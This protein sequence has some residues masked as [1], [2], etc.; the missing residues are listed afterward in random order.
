PGSSRRR[1]RRGEQRWDEQAG[2]ATNVLLVGGR[3]DGPSGSGVESGGDALAH[4]RSGFVAHASRSRRGAA[5]LPRS[6][7]SSRGGA[8]RPPHA[9]RGPQGTPR[10]PAVGIRTSPQTKDQ[11]IM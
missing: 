3:G 9:E 2:P 10:H 4:Q 7:A 6:S 8:D 5:P 1:V 11:R